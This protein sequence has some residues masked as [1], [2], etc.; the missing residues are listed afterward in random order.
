MT[1][2]IKVVAER[3]KS[4]RLAVADLEQANSSWISGSYMKMFMQSSILGMR[5]ADLRY[6]LILVPLSTVGG[7]DMV[8]SLV[9]NQ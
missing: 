7:G 4:E 9:W 1:I 2:D 8:T 3:N 6:G 5:V